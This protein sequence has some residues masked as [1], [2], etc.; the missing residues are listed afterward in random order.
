[1][2]SLGLTIML[3]SAVIGSASCNLPMIHE[4][5]VPVDIVIAATTDVHGYVRGWDYYAN[6]PD[7]TRGL[8]RVATIVDSLRRVSRVWPV[9]VD[10]GDFLQG[11]PLT[12]AAARLDT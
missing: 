5:N 1:M 11:N 6:A 8:A 2:R 12:Y 3:A 7:T 10:A 9:L 4:A